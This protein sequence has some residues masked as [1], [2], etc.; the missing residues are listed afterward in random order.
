MGGEVGLCAAALQ[1]GPTRSDL[2]AGPV[3]RA[4]RKAM[5]GVS[6]FIKRCSMQCDR[7]DSRASTR[8]RIDASEQHAGP[9]RAP[10]AAR[11][12]R[13]RSGCAQATCLTDRAG[14]YVPRRPCVRAAALSETVPR[15]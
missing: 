12:S 13:G 2:R 8:A 1:P 15:R 3:R 5:S 10:V 11:R 14:C 4:R 9:H 6:I 7:A